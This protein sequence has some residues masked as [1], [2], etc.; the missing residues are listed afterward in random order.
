MDVFSALSDPTRRAIV[1]ELQAKDG[2]S[3]FELCAR[4]VTNHALTSTR[5]AVSQHLEVL[6]RV[7]LVTSRR[8]GR[9][10]LLFLDTSPLRPVI[11]RWL[12]QTPERRSGPAESREELNPRRTGMRVTWV[13]L[14]VDDQERARRF[15]T[16]T[17][18]FLVKHDVP[19]GA[20]RWLT[21][22]SATDRDGVELV[23][24]PAAHPAV[25]RFRAALAADG[26]PAH[27]F[28]VDD[29]DS[30]YEHLRSLGVHFTQR[31]AV[32]GAT[33]TA[34]FDDTCGNL[35][36]IHHHVDQRSAHTHR[37]RGEHA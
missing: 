27:S 30:E 14:F 3:L 23:L 11:D 5:Q 19:L 6:E 22:V 21:L 1:D 28:A 24:E 25:T 26:I 15:Y 34:V 10:K 31:P 7:G 33:T 35:I 16:E 4:L 36:Q 13:T 17:L 9:Y 12:E 37:E 32:M 29:V 8:E 18:G 2:Q 20:D